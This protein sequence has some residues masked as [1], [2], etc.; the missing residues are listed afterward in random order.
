MALGFSTIDCGRTIWGKEQHN[1][2]LRFDGGGI[3]EGIMPARR[4]FMPSRV[5]ADSTLRDEESLV[6]HFMPVWWWAVGMWWD[7]EFCGTEAVVCA[8][9][10]ST[11]RILKF[12]N[13]VA[14]Q[15][16]SRLP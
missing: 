1:L 13:A 8:P 4:T 12:H 10:P 9:T 3:L 2:V 16:E 6:M 7:D 15:C 5:K 14:Y 11:H